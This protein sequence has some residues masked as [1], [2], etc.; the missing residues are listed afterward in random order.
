[1]IRVLMVSDVYFPRV[2]GVST[3]METFRQALARQGVEVRLVVP[4]YADEADE[5]GIIR[6]AG[7]RLPNDPEDRLLPW[8]EMHRTVRAAASGCD[9]I[10]V[11]TPFIAH[12]AGVAAARHHGLPA[13]VTYH[14]LF[15]EYLQ[16]H[17]IKGAVSRDA[18]DGLVHIAGH[19]QRQG[20]DL[21][22]VLPAGDGR[23]PGLPA[24]AV[25]LHQQGLAGV[26]GLETVGFRRAGVPAALIH[27]SG[28]VPVAQGQVIEPGLHGAAGGDGVGRVDAVGQDALH[29]AVGQAD[30]RQ[31]GRRFGAG[32]PLGEIGVG[33]ALGERRRQDGQRRG[34]HNQRLGLQAQ[35]DVGRHRPQPHSPRPHRFGEAGVV[36]AG[37]HQP[38]P[39]KAGHG[40]KQ[41]VDGLVG[42]ALG[43]EHV[44]RHQDGIDALIRGQPGQ[45][46]DGGETG[47]GQNGGLVGFELPEELAD[48]P[49]GGVQE[50]DHGRARGVDRYGGRL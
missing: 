22:A 24:R 48:L 4:R 3:S 23:N 33:D 40:V 36:V 12:Y 7:R 16:L 21:P 2:N 38:R 15:E 6:V 30:A 44:T 17:H 34:S 9:L 28:A 26:V 42:H 27:L 29:A 8:G 41:A 31:A 19:L 25:Q 32:K 10:H 47:F 13:L 45:A 14:T 5:P 37:N 43:V 50:L 20:F 46:L 1:M 11:Q 39:G 18:L 35:G 49:V